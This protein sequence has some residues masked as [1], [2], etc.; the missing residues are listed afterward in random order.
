MWVRYWDA[1]YCKFEQIKVRLHLVGCS[2][3]S[4]EFSLWQ[5]LLFHER[6]H[7]K[8]FNVTSDLSGTRAAFEN[9]SRP[10][11]GLL[12]SMPLSVDAFSWAYIDVHLDLS[13]QRCT[14]HWASSLQWVLGVNFYCLFSFL[15]S[16]RWP[17]ILT[18]LNKSL[19]SKI[20]LGFPALKWLTM[21]S[22]LIPTAWFQTE[23]SLGYIPAVLI[24]ISRG[25]F[26]KAIKM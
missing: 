1:L 6:K 22:R 24:C 11:G 5:H 10:T 20:T 7:V 17:I 21:V 19:T 18:T 16:H 26:V 9:F 25:I 12:G 14:S 2:G 23:W 8:Q 3:L 15:P 13:T 4:S